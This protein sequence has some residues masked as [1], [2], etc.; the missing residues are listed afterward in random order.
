LQK[1]VLT[2]LISIVALSTSFAQ[3]EE[4]TKFPMLEIPKINNNEFVI[5]H[6]GYSFL[7]HEEFEQ[8]SWVAY[9]LT[10]EETNKTVE[11]TN[12]FIQD[13]KVITGT[14]NDND[15]SGSGYDR[16]HLAPASDMG[17]SAT[18]MAESFYYSNISPQNPS[19]NRGIWKK[20]EEQVRTWAIENNSIFIVTGPVLTKGLTTIGANKV[21][22]PTYFF[23]VILD[24]NEPNIKGIGFIIP[25]TGSSELLNTYTVT[26]D[27]VEKLT[28]IDFFTTLPDTQETLIEKTLCINCWSWKSIKTG[29]NK[30]NKSS[31][32]AVQCNGI[33][34][35]GNRCNNK[36]LNKSG[37]CYL[38]EEQNK[39]NT[40]NPLTPIPTKTERKTIS[41]QCLGTTKKG[42]R[43][44][45]L[46][47][48]PN[49]F[50]YQHG[51]N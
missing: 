19:F 3:Q 20:L 49:G 25:N 13:S 6:T 10:K 18:V 46:T 31:S 43:C 9:E 21:A 11:R 7:Y 12:K 16:G 22:V 34:K 30:K 8:A 47:Y 27:S 15:Y 32:S 35:V 2:I 45:H 4:T 40:D 41:E 23:K 44:K 42:N 36:T 5:R 48:N 28:G 38:H 26:I 37:Y 24:D 50:C 17:W 1:Q 14:A 33:T 51:G 29:N 39:N